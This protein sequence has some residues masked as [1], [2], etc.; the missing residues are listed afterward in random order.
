[1]ANYDAVAISTHQTLA[2][3]TEDRVTFASDL[4]LVI[5]V[6]RGSGPLY[7][8][9]G[10]DTADDPAAATVAGAGTHVLLAGERTSVYPVTGEATRVR[11]IATGTEAYSV[12][13]GV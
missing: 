8:T 3:V 6:N 2:A 9:Y 1:M 13:A 12:E 7:F 10:G 4:D 5:I 11:L